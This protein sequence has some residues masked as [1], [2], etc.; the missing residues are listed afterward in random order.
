MEPHL[1]LI[2]IGYS[3]SLAIVLGFGGFVLSQ[4]W[5]T[6]L[7]RVF[8]AVC[9]AIAL[10]QIDYIWAINTA[11]PILAY[12]LWFANA[13]SDVIIG[14]LV[15]Q[16]FVLA[17]NS[18]ERWRGVM[19]TMYIAA[20]ILVLTAC[21]LPRM[22]L[23][24]VQIPALYFKSYSGMSGA[25]YYLPDI[26][27]FAAF[28]LAYI[29]LLIA[30][31][32]AGEEGKKRIGYYLLG[33]TYGFVT[34]L[35]AFAP[36]FNIPIDPAWS[37]LI[38][39]FVIPFAYGMVKKDLMDIGIAIRGTVVYTSIIVAITAVLTVVSLLSNWMMSTIPGFG[40]WTVPL[41]TALVSVVVGGLYWRK[42]GEAE[43]L[44]Y[45]FITVVT[46]KFRT[47]LTRIRWQSE[48]LREQP[49][50]APESKAGIQQI[51]DSSIELIRLSNLLI[52]AV[53]MERG[54]YQYTWRN[55]SL[56]ELAR[57]TLTSF[58]TSAQAKHIEMT[59]Q[60]DRKIPFVRA[61]EERLA[62]AIH[63]L[64]ENAL[65]Y[66]PANGTI[67][68]SITDDHDTVKFA[69]TDTG[70][71]VEKADLSRLF[72]RFYRGERARRAD[73][74]GVGLGLSMAKTIIQRHR[75]TIGVDSPGIG[76]GSTFWFTLPV[77]H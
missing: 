77:V 75:G 29:V 48:A 10:Y 36:D 5:H 68:I 21:M 26:Y 42:A 56:E 25:L 2:T 16:F 52:D 73:T 7:N 8:F 15:V 47:P 22:Y 28:A 60:A 71:G 69:V 24:D 38:G 54:S 18:Q 51:T 39:T 27:F 53:K 46:H 35:A 45:E 11:E 72:S 67:T 74:E 50:L 70:I 14:V 49:S 44:K 31:K 64:V 62:S 57:K 58:S 23:A 4:G 55:L 6:V 3:I 66:T 37:A 59:L 76:K 40:Y 41:L 30:R 43:Q 63:V 1:L 20:G 32:G 61:D 9:V 13:L 33:L 17:T 19:K 65:S 12:W 34:G